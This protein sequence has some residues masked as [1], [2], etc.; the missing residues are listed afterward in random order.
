MID[1]C[2]PGIFIN[3]EELM[4]D[5]DRRRPGDKGT[6]PRKEYDLPEI[7]SGVFNGKTTGAPITIV[8]AN[9][10]KISSD[11][12]KLKN[13]PRPGHADMTAF[14]K[15]KGNADTRGGGHFSGRLTWGLVVAGTFARKI[16]SPAIIDA[17]IS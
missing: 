12:D 5:L 14:L 16:I 11:Y 7:L 15:Y 8:T 2:P 13:V 17:K 10:N 1:G 6:T 3:M 4:M 9:S